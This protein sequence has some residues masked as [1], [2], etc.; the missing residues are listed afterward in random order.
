M[1][2]R[3]LLHD[4]CDKM[5]THLEWMFSFIF[6]QRR[7]K[8]C[9]NGFQIVEFNLVDRFLTYVMVHKLSPVKHDI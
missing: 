7:V 9:L 4:T 3:L 6:R 5:S 2:Q 1:H 8:M